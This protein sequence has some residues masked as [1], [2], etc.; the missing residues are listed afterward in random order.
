MHSASLSSRSVGN[1][2]FD[3]GRAL[4]GQVYMH[5]RKAIVQMHLSPGQ[6]VSEQDI[7]VQLGVSRQPV[8]EAFIKLQEMRLVRIVPQ[9]GTYVAGV[10]LS[11]VM[12][13][14]FIRQAVETAI[15]RAAC[16]VAPDQT[17][18][19]LMALIELQKK[20]IRDEDQP[21][22]L[23]HDEAFHRALVDAVDCSTAWS[24]LEDAKVH[25]DRVRY[26]RTPEMTPLG[27]LVKQ[28]SSIVAAI[29]A[30]DPDAAVARMTEHLSEI[31]VVLPRL[32]KAYPN[33]FDDLHVP[34]HMT[35]QAPDKMA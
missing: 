14:R 26:F 9:R 35:G 3:P 31:L 8:R 32:A 27:V 23:D 25:M 18:D 29:R 30:R 12:N 16:R 10:S 19:A 2:V 17:A 1:K 4:G 5:L 22:F 28:H 33:L 24:V 13:A 34:R 6:A 7:A 15:V 21:A 20:A 11:E